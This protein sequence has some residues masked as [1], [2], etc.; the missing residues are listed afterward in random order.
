MLTAAIIEDMKKYCATV[1]MEFH[2]VFLITQNTDAQP[3]TRISELAKQ[4]GQSNI[5]H[6]FFYSRAFP[7]TDLWLDTHYTP[8]GQALL[9]EHIAEVIDENMQPTK[10]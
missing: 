10:Q 8:Y 3:A 1:N 5:P 2:V 9:A 7:R 4:L 6:S